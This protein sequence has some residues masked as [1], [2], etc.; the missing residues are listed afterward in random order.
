[1]IASVEQMFEYSQ[2]STIDREVI[3]SLRL[4]AQELDRNALPTFANAI[5]ASLGDTIICP[6]NAGWQALLSSDSKPTICV[7]AVVLAKEALS[8]NA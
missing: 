6:A 4:L 5:R 3:K 2:K 7:L 8:S 1:M